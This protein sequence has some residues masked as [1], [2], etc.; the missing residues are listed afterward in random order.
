MAKTD[1]VYNKRA[2]LR[3][4]CLQYLKKELC[5]L[6]MT[7]KGLFIKVLKGGGKYDKSVTSF[8]KVP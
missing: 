8:M 1:D 5:N 6:W 3:E 2:S 4:G 7:D